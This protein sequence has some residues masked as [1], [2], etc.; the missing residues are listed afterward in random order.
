[1]N[2][3]WERFELEGRVRVF[4]RFTEPGGHGSAEETGTGGVRAFSQQADVESGWV[5]SK[6]GW[7]GIYHKMRPTHR[8]R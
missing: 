3:Q 2:G 1:M 8:N 7:Y 5:L 6:R 4:V